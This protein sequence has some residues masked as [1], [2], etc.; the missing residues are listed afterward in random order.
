[1][2]AQQRLFLTAPKQR[3]ATM[4]QELLDDGDALV[5]VMKVVAGTFC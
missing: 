1:M 3:A 4:R 2:L 5:R